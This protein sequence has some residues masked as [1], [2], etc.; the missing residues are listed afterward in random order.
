MHYVIFSYLL[1]PIL[2]LEEGLSVCHTELGDDSA[3]N[4]NTPMLRYVVA[5]GPLKDPPVLERA[6]EG[7]V[8]RPRHRLHLEILGGVAI[9]VGALDLVGVPHVAIVGL[10]AFARQEVAREGV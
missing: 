8:T 10:D 4:E 5:L 3:R 1:I 2:H 7:L 6:I 9:V